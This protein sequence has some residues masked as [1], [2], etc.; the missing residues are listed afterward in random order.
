MTSCISNKFAVL[1]L[2]LAHMPAGVIPPKVSYKIYG[3]NHLETVILIHGFNSS[4]VTWKQL[5]ESLSKKYRVITFDQPGHGLSP[6]DG[7]DYS[8]EKLAHILKG[9][10]DFLMVEKAHI[11][12]HSM[13]G[14]S[15]LMFASLYP[16]KTSSL[17]IEDMDLRQNR[18]FESRIPDLLKQYEPVRWTIPD[19]FGNLQHAKVALSEFYTA[20]EIMW[21]LSVSETLD[22]GSVR[23]GN[24]PEVTG[25]YLAQGLALDM[26]VPLQS[27][28]VPTTFFAG[29]PAFAGTVLKDAGIDHIRENRPDLTILEFPSSGH[30]I[31][32][33]PEFKIALEDFWNDLK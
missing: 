26:T 7:T 4:Q 23:L 18:E 30:T 24:R 16:E 13:G 22:D 6:A 9:L 15:A 27:V 17:I 1:S 12:G 3:E 21:I 19:V 8:P 10:V 33:R 11:I 28:S 25:L 5:A 20:T 31:H 32:N 14:R 2:T 29:D